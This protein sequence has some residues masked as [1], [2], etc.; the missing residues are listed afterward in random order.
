MGRPAGSPRSGCRWSARRPVRGHPGTAIWKRG[1]SVDR[2][3]RTITFHL[4]SPTRPSSTSSR[5]LFAAAVPS[6][7]PP[8]GAGRTAL[9]AAT[10]PYVVS[11]YAPDHEELSARNPIFQGSTG[12]RS[13][14][15]PDRIVLRVGVSPERQVGLVELGRADVMLNTPPPDELATIARQAPLR[16]HAY[17][18][19]ELHAMFM[20]TRRAPFDRVAV[21]R[22]V[23]F[24]VDRS[25]IVRLEGGEQL[26][27]PTC[28]VLPPGFPGYRPSCPY[29]AD[30]SVVG[31]LRRPDLAR[32]RRLIR[33]SGTS[34]K[35]VA[36]STPLGDP[37]R[38]RTA[39]YFVGLL[40]R[41]GYR[42][43]L[44]TYPS[45]PAYFEGAGLPRSRSQI[46]ID[47][48][49]ADFPAGSSFFSPL[50]GCEPYEVGVLNLNAARF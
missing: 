19:P 50:F 23:N 26:A 20:N 32:A 2:A 39:R 5:C 41:L 25:A 6:G 46:G 27:Q 40:E 44:R 11:H 9:P 4:T 37:L 16:A 22:A 34:G 35:A 47:P 17:F 15:F 45:D 42:A 14:G 18:F 30:T 38:V 3:D 24:A 13:A 48:W 36:V 31:A 10:G 8:I 29:S 1:I 49:V 43:R 12:V 7:S 28:Q 33:R 21:R